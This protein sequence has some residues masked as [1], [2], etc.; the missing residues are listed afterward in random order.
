MYNQENMA[1]MYILKCSDG[2]YYTGST[3]NIELRFWQ[4]ELGK[5]SRYTSKRLPVQLV[6]FEQFSRIDEAFQREKQIQ[7]WSHAKK[8]ALINSD[9]KNLKRLSQSRFSED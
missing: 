3:R 8:E 6:Y 4:H 5:G 1:Y 9:Y 2:S 7:G